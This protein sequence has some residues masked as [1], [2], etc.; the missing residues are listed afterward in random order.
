MI[1]VGFQVY[2]RRVMHS[3]RYAQL[4][5]HGIR[6]EAALWVY[7]AT[8]E[9]FK[10]RK[11]SHHGVMELNS[12]TTAQATQTQGEVTAQQA[13]LCGTCYDYYSATYGYYGYYSPG[14]TYLTEV[15]VDCFTE[16]FFNYCGNCAYLIPFIGVPPFYPGAG[17]VLACA[18]VACPLAI[19]AYC[20][21]YQQFAGYDYC[22]SCYYE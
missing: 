9:S 4:V 21:P 6:S 11:S 17:A 13:D 22:V 18:L 10:R 3:Y 2:N 16:E 14:G 1:A 7:D 19:T 5:N 20:G 8:T 12:T 15:F